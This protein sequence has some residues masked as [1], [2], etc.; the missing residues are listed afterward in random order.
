MGS[1]FA[2]KVESGLGK[3]GIVSIKDERVGGVAGYYFDG[4]GVP[5]AQDWLEG[6]TLAR[7]GEG[8]ERERFGESSAKGD[9]VQQRLVFDSF[10]EQVRLSTSYVDNTFDTTLHTETLK[11]D[12]DGTTRR[13]LP[14]VGL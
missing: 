12:R 14:P 7:L 6:V 11:L 8:W 3:T 10:N 1:R 5:R 13:D 2:E 9:G 4:L